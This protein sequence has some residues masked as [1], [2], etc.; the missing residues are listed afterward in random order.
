[1]HELGVTFH[2][3]DHVEKVAEENDVSKVNKVVLQLG[4]V[5]TVIE[6]Y[7]LNCWKWAAKKRELFS[8]CELVIETLREEETQVRQIL[9]EN[10]KSAANLA[11]SLEVDLHTG[12]NWY[13]A[14]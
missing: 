11:V 13:E 2:I 9:E 6:S 12:E 3:M 7:L 5:S 8:D 10:M 14:K 4:E 1:M